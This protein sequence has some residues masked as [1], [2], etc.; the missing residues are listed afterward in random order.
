MYTH[1]PDFVFFSEIAEFAVITFDFM[2]A[3]D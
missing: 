1:L 2:R 3:C